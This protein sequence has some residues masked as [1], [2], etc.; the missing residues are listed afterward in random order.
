MTDAND[1]VFDPFMGVGTTAVAG[2]M[3]GRKVIG[4]E[5]MKE[6]IEIALQRIKMAEDGL[7]RI[8]SMNRPVFN[9]N[10]PT[11]N[12]PPRVVKISSFKEQLDIF[13]ESDKAT[14]QPA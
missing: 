14:H 8:R 1:W 3:H 7:L 10:I 9:P 13:E 11:K 6:Y 4:S 2:L 5:I 12:I